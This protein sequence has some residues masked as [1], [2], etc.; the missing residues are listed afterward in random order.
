MSIENLSM[1]MENLSKL[2]REKKLPGMT[3]KFRDK[4][5]SLKKFLNGS[6][7]IGFCLHRKKSFVL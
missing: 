3:G 1:S 7:N 5:I 2:A 4:L 6:R